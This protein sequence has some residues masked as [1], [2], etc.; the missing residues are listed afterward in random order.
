MA[1]AAFLFGRIRRRL[2]PDVAPYEDAV[3]PDQRPVLR[4]TLLSLL[5]HPAPYAS[6]VARRNPHLGPTLDA[7]ERKVVR[8]LASPR[9]DLAA[10]EA[11]HRERV[12]RALPRKGIVRLCADTSDISKPWARHLEALDRVR[13]GSDPEKRTNPGYWL[14][15]V[16]AVPRRGQVTPVVFE[17]FSLKAEG[18]RS[19]NEVLLRGIEAAFEVA[20]GR[21]VLIADR[22]Y[23][24]GE[25]FKSLIP[26]ARPFVIRLQS[27]SSSRLL[28]LP[29]SGSKA[30]VQ[31]I[32]QGLPLSHRLDPDEKARKP[33]RGGLG[34]RAVRLPA[35]PETDLTLV[36]FQTGY[37]EPLVVLTS[38]PVPDL[39]AARRVVRLYLDRWSGAEDPIRFLKQGFR[40]E[41][42]LLTTLRAQRAMAF[43]VAIAMSLLTALLGAGPLARALVGGIEW[44]REQV[45]LLHYRLA[46]AVAGVLERLPPRRWRAFAGASPR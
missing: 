26:T 38:L 21:G 13:D 44:F 37:R 28:G 19:Q 42:G 45:D 32:V 2:E 36:V 4:A 25:V 7:R 27:G 41:K 3:R 31:K 6:E 30:T 20:P 11:A 46:R 39:R 40:L 35:H 22:G 1:R 17:V 9:L 14:N 12:R 24:S 5:S 29:D 15:G 34:W 10:L 18:T 16:Y 43:L 8:F 33:D 23:D